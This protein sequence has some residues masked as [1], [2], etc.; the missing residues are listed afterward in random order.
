MAQNTPVRNVGL[1]PIDTK[2]KTAPIILEKIHKY[3]RPLM[4]FNPGQLYLKS[5]KYYC[6]QETANIKQYNKSAIHY[7]LVSFENELAIKLF[8]WPKN[9]AQILEQWH[10]HWNV[11]KYG[12]QETPEEK[13]VVW[14]NDPN[15]ETQIY[16]MPTGNYCPHHIG[17]NDTEAILK[18]RRGIIDDNT[19][20]WLSDRHI[21]GQFLPAIANKIHKSI[22]VHSQNNGKHK[23]KLLTQRILND[24]T[25]EN[26]N[27][28]ING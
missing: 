16:R 15:I 21:T 7:I 22:I 23:C 17:G 19:I 18:R 3:G 10:R 6:G 14:S 20:K 9:V 8:P 26:N 2:H 27:N 1:I 13:V 4:I 28:I 24:L 12:A 11:S 5:R 25:H